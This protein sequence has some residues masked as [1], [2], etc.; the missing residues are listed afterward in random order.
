VRRLDR[1]VLAVL[2]AASIAAPGSAIAQQPPG[3]ATVDAGSGQL[4]LSMT[5]QIAN[6]DTLDFHGVAKGATSL[7]LQIYPDLHLRVADHSGAVVP[8]EHAPIDNHDAKPGSCQLSGSDVHWKISLHALYPNLQPG[9]YTLQASLALHDAVS[10]E[11][12]LPPAPFTVGRVM[13]AYLPLAPRM[14]S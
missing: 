3:Y 1:F 11:L 5:Y 10:S 6:P 14:H 2:A 12:T 4:S 9:K 7:C 13:V 8:M